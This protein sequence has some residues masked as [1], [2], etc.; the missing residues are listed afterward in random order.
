MASV[1]DFGQSPPN[2]F[3]NVHSLHFESSASTW[4]YQDGGR[5]GIADTHIPTA[6]G[7]DSQTA[8]HILGTDVLAS[9]TVQNELYVVH[10]FS[11]WLI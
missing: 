9:D 10:D 11:I 3:V 4:A 7:G 6:A 1:G 8:Q 5:F 2:S